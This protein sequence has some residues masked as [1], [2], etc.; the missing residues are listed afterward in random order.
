MAEESGKKKIYIDIC[1][2]IYDLDCEMIH[3]TSK[4]EN[5]GYF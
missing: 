4:R 2:Y 1:V 5:I 3:S